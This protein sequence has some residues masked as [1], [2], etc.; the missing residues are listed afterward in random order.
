MDAVHWADQGCANQKDDGPRQRGF[1]QERGCETMSDDL[2]NWQPR[3][4]PL[5]PEEMRRAYQQ[6]TN[7]PDKT[8]ASAARSRLK[9]LPEE[10]EREPPV[11][12][13]AT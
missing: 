13:G 11:E 1:P 7:H 10:I 12:D 6:L 9:L 4:R 8:V 3:A 2:V 5:T